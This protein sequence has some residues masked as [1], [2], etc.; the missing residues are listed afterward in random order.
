MMTEAQRIESAILIGEA[1]LNSASLYLTRV[2]A[3][4][5][6]AYFVGANLSRYSQVF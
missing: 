3:Y 5:V 1:A 2:T 4:L 6:A